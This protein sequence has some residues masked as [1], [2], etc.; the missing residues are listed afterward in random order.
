MNLE[1]LL[2]A[3][4]IFIGRITDVTLGTIRVNMIVRKKKVIAS[5][6]GFFEVVIFVT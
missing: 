3:L 6:I 1:T 2:L 4:L 5:I